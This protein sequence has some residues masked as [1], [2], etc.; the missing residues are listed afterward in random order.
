MAA[1]NYDFEAMLNEYLCHKDRII[2]K[3]EL[4]IKQDTLKII[5]KK[6]LHFFLYC[7]IF[8]KYLITEI[9]GF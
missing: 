1:I 7:T 9:K 5:R 8:F 4:G 6:F 3:V 2:L